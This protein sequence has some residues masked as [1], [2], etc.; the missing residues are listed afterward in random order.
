VCQWS[1]CDL[2]RDPFAAIAG[3]AGQREFVPVFARAAVSVGIAGLF[4]ETNPDPSKALS[5][6]PNAWPLGLS[7]PLLVEL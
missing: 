1:T 3:R 5:D 2:R 7:E 6:G 4:M